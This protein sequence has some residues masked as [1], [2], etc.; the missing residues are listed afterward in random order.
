MSREAFQN[1]AIGSYTLDSKTMAMAH[2]AAGCFGETSYDLSK[3]F[4][5]QQQVGI[6]FARSADYINGMT[7]G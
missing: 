5:Q 7:L 4:T 6:N 2:K 3:I 1:A